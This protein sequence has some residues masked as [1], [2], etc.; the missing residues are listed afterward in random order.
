MQRWRKLQFD[1]SYVSKQKCRLR[2]SSQRWL[3]PV[4]LARHREWGVS[5]GGGTP[6]HALSRS[7]GPIFQ[8]DIRK[9]LTGRWV[10]VH[11][12][13]WE[14]ERV[15]E[16]GGW[17]NN[18]PASERLLLLASVGVQGS[19][20][21]V[22]ASSLSFFRLEILSRPSRSIVFSSS[23]SHPLRMHNPF[24]QKFSNFVRTFRA[25]IAIISWDSLARSR[26][27]NYFCK[28]I[29]NAEKFSVRFL[30]TCAIGCNR[31]SL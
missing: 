8:T 30:E 24:P 4:G 17:Q 3:S 13:G 19:H 18:P 22:C 26:I 23:L 9:E 27:T 11:P 14:T 29:A 6:R 10:A 21:V 15:L 2:A 1:S 28:L 25:N 20:L 16:A 5:L 31:V 7:C 12:R